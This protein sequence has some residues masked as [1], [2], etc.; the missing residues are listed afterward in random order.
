MLS[1]CGLWIPGAEFPAAEAVSNSADQ[2]VIIVDKIR[3][4]FAAKQQA[5]A[6][7]C[8]NRQV[9]T[10]IPLVSQKMLVT[11]NRNNEKMCKLALGSTPSIILEYLT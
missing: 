9:D 2:V 4:Y 6:I 1:E 7:S 5:I 8:R 10:I 11:T 3:S